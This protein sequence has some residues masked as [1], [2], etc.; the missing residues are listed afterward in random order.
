MNKA[1]RTAGPIELSLELKRA[2][3]AIRAQLAISTSSEIALE[4][5]V[6]VEKHVG[7]TIPDDLLAL[8]AATGQSIGALVTM[9]DT[10][11]DYDEVEGEKLWR[12]RFGFCHVVFDDSYS[13]EEGL[14]CAELGSNPASISFW[15]LRKG[16]A[17]APIFL[18]EGVPPLVSYCRWKYPTV[19]FSVAVDPTALA[20]LEPSIVVPALPEVR[21]VKHPKFGD[22]VVVRAIAP[23]KLEIDFG[24]HG[25][26]KLLASTVEDTREQ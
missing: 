23:D 3:V 18:E 7:G 1:R 15:F 10:I 21:R 8:F 25:V 4:G 17:W 12:R 14:L 16:M 20:A 5:V 13:P 11:G 9:T 26:R 19:D 22:G 24:T 6:A 2:L